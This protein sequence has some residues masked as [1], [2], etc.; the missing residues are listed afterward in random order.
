MCK[1][2]NGYIYAT[3]TR[4]AAHDTCMYTWLSSTRH[5][6]SR[7]V[8]ITIF[9]R[10]ELICKKKKTYALINE[11]SLNLNRLKFLINERPLLYCVNDYLILIKREKS[12]TGLLLYKHFFYNYNI[13]NS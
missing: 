2:V 8:D 12:S 5:A 4:H 6:N 10:S 13:K 11:Y 9:C 7:I 3:S 1:L